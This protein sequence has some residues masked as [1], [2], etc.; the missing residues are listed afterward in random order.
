MDETT[1]EKGQD[2]LSLEEALALLGLKDVP[3]GEADEG[4]ILSGTNQLMRKYGVDW[5]KA[6]R[7][8]LVE[9]LQILAEF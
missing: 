3:G 7:V 2:S 1:P 6:N 4:L 5:I 9:E 8:R